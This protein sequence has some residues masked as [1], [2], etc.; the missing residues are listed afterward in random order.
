MQSGEQGVLKA[1]WSALR[2]P[3]APEHRGDLAFGWLI[4]GLFFLQVFTGILLSLYY[5]PSPPMVAESVQYIM[6]DVDWGWL[7]R[8][9]H[10]WTSHAMI[11]VCALHLL[12]AVITG[13]YRGAGTPNWYAGTL[14]MAVVLVATY[15]G[16]LLTW[17]QS[18]YWRLTGALSRIASFGSVGAF[19]ADVARGGS[20]VNATTLSRTY[21]AHSLL[22]PW[23]I[24]VL[25][26]ANLWFLGRRLGV[27]RGGSR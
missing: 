15:T 22:L 4:L 1:I 3:V 6:R 7:V 9:V 25:L 27:R 2:I 26:V 8:G 16:D 20:E 19:F 12:R 18:S 5:Q 21:S 10:H 17:D 11:V 13:S 14:V 23:M 24:W